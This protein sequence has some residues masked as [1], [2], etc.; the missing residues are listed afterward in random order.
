MRA[1]IQGHAEVIRSLQSKGADVNASNAN[2]RTALILATAAGRPGAVAALLQSGA[3]ASAK[4][5]NGTTALML[6]EKLGRPR[7][8]KLLRATR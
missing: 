8:A 1:S 6:A 3:D 5:R 7:I 2:G 4:D